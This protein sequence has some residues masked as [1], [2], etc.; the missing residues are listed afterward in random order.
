VT[1]GSA[2]VSQFSTGTARLDL[3]GA[4]G[5][6]FVEITDNL[7][8]QSGAYTLLLQTPVTVRT[9]PLRPSLG[10]RSAR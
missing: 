10:S 4:A 5:T 9:L 7:N 2:C 1:G 3:L 8:N 6:Y